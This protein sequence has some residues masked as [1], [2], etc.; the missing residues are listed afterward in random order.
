MFHVP[1]VQGIFSQGQ[2]N[3]SFFNIFRRWEQ[4][5]ESFSVLGVFPFLELRSVNRCHF[6]SLLRH[7]LTRFT[8]KILDWEFLEND[9]SKR[10]KHFFTLPNSQYP[11]SNADVLWGRG[12]GSF[13]WWSYD[14]ITSASEA[15][16]PSRDGSGG[17]SPLHI[18]ERQRAVAP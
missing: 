14:C 8:P 17:L 15:P 1:S 18:G 16:A 9:F 10:I 2:V 4:V 7:L 12:I 11:H 6:L 5:W 13:F 3:V